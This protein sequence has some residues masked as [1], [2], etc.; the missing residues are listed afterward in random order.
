MGGSPMGVSGG[1]PEEKAWSKGD[2][3]FQLGAPET[4]VSRTNVPPQE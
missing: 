1:P 4:Y 3:A 2:Q